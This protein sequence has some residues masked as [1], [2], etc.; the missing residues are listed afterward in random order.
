M[1]FKS[2]ME[3]YWPAYKE[4]KDK[5]LEDLQ[6]GEASPAPS[7]TP[8]I[9]APHWECVRCHQKFETLEELQTHYT[10]SQIGADP[11]LV[12]QSRRG[13]TEKSW[14]RGQKVVNAPTIRSVM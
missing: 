11:T 6:S 10:H 1:K 12:P 4:S 13:Y 14:R 8:G 5:F 3:E 9:V 7:H 2:D